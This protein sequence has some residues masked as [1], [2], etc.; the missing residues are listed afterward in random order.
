MKNA[1]FWKPDSSIIALISDRTGSILSNI[2]L[3]TKE[4]L[5]I[6]SCCTVSEDSTDLNQGEYFNCLML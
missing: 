1:H 3:K 2:C 5:N 4:P 6:L